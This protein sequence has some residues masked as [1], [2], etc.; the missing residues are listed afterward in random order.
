MLDFT[1]KHARSPPQYAA[2]MET[3]GDRIRTLRTARGLT[4]DAVA[5]HC[6]VTKSAVSQWELQQ[7]ANIKLPAFL[8]LCE[9]LGTDPH[10]LV[11]GPGRSKPGP[12]PGP[13]APR[14]TARS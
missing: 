3:L 7:S 14:R 6:G 8:L 2:G 1:V 5:R 13:D 12:V 11:W 10:Y 4:L 9:L